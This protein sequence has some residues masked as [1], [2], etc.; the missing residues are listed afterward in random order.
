LINNHEEIGHPAAGLPPDVE[1][2]VVV[3]M[4]AVGKGQT[5]DEFHASLCAKDSSGPYHHDLSNQLR[6][7]A[8][9]HEISYKVDVYTYYSSDGAATLRAGNDLRVA[10]IGPGVDASHNYERTHMDALLATTQWVMAYLLD[11]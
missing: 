8:D 10:L 3:D 7:L 1:E 5:S 9:K 11:E 4:A 6:Y 2:L